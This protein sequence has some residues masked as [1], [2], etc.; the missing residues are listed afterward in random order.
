MEIKPTIKG[1]FV[2]SHI[3][4]V[5][6]LKGEQ[7]VLELEK[8]FGKPLR[9]RNGENVLVRE[10]VKLIELALDILT[11]HRFP[12]EER[13]F[14]AG[15]LHFRN[16]TTTPLAHIIFSQ[17]RKN[18]KLLLMQAKHITGHVFQGVKFSSTDLGPTS[19][20]I[21][22]KNNDYPLDHFKGLFYE[23]ILFA[24]YEGSVEARHIVPDQ[25]EYTVVWN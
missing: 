13:A 19:V 21:I 23:W 25:Y 1:I 7:G 3:K 12:V 24:G 14:E 17:F 16:F 5:R 10:E 8:R 15:R 20:K 18:M 2:N 6:E 9:F 4:I 11:D 22:M